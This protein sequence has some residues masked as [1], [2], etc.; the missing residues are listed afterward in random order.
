MV[1]YGQLAGNNSCFGNLIGFHCKY[2]VW[3]R[4][5]FAVNFKFC[6]PL[7]C[8]FFDTVDTEFDSFLFF[9]GQSTLSKE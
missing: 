5:P 9:V 7:N 1:G 4:C 3:P 6:S 8:F 2:W